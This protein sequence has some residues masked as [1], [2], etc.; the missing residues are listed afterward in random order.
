MRFRVLST[1]VLSFVLLGLSLVSSTRAVLSQDTGETCHPAIQAAL[2]Q[3]GNLCDGLSRNSACYGNT[4]VEATFADLAADQSF[5]KPGDT[6]DVTAIQSINTAPLDEESDIWGVSLLKLQA[7]LPDTL[8][9]QGVV[10]VLF[11]D[12][13]VENAVAPGDLFIPRPVS[14]AVTTGS[15]ANIRSAPSTNASVFFSVP[16]GTELPA[17]ATSTDEEWLRVVSGTTVGWVNKGVVNA[18]ANEVDELPLLTRSARSPMQS[19]YLT[20]SLSDVSCSKAPPLVV[21]QGPDNVKVDLTVNG[22]NISMAST[23]VVR[24]T[25][26]HTLEVIAVHGTVRVN[27][28][29]LPPGFAVRAPLSADGHSQEGELIDIH[30]MVQAE[31]DGLTSVELI[32]ANV[33]NYAIKLPTVSEI[34][35]L[36]AALGGG[37][38]VVSAAAAAHVTCRSL[39]LTSPLDSWGRQSTTFYWDP[40]PGATSYR[41]NI[42]TV[43]SIE[44]PSTS[45]NY[46]LTTVLGVENLTW[47]VQ[48]LYKGE[49]ACATRPLTLPRNP[50]ANGGG[51]GG[52]GGGGC[53]YDMAT[54]T[55]VCS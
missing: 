28:V 4:Q 39:K 25:D 55:M 30:P 12:V 13:G 16:A 6:A 47:S 36:A 20:S 44:T 18:S 3:V 40:A 22:V 50:Y 5:A 21:I 17:D 27:D 33:L 14:V 45:V 9:G 19:F 23:I 7:N 51:S 10:F 32:P 53:H 46:D 48:A 34:N 42:D 38:G 1:L 31:L 29:P 35:Q 8:P 24:L 2:Q 37:G 41:L 26:A 52:G 11:G 15:A 54:H 43:G 49:V